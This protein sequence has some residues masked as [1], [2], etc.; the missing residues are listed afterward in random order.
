[1]AK[2]TQVA[3]FESQDS[4]ILVDVFTNFPYKQASQLVDVTEHV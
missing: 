3:Q 4:Q 1:M 2:L